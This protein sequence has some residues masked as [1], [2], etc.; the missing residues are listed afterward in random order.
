[1]RQTTQ[2]IARQLCPQPQRSR[3]LQQEAAC[4]PQRFLPC[5][6]RQRFH[7]AKGT[8]V[9]T[10]AVTAWHK[11][12]AAGAGVDTMAVNAAWQ[13]ADCRCRP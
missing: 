11:V 8:T 13:A 1:M 6:A 9:L 2:V 3:Q 4:A 10:P 7:I 12:P 5:S